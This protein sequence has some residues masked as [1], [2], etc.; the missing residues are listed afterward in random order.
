MSERSRFG[1]AAGRLR[2]LASQA[3]GRTAPVEA[4][5]AGL[6]DGRRLW[7]ALPPGAGEVAL[8]GP[9]GAHVRLADELAEEA[10]EGATEESAGRTPAWRAVRLD[11]E[12]LAGAEPASYAVVVG[13]GAAPVSLPE[14]AWDRV[15]PIG[16]GEGLRMVLERGRDGTLAVRVRPPRVGR[17]LRTVA[18]EGGDALLGCTPGSGGGGESF[19]LLDKNGDVAVELAGEPEEGLLR[20]LIS[21][22]DLPEV[23]GPYRV[24]I[25]P[26]RV[27]VVRHADCLEDASPVLLPF[28]VD[29]EDR[30]VARLRFRPDGQ[31]VVRRLPLLRE[32]SG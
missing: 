3:L 12:P 5:Y 27:P 22:A 20:C 2:S 17:P 14:E 15:A 30:A 11:L 32:Q 26:E 23:P 4:G 6:L 9:D 24:T 8:V 19:F 25:G 29:D 10:P 31:L 13:D 21:D 1:R 28:I 16:P 18:Y 7:L